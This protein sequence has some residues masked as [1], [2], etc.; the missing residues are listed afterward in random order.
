MS[1]RV[2]R[3]ALVALGSL[4]DLLPFYS[5]AK[6]LGLRG[7]SPTILASPLLER[8]LRG[9]TELPL[10]AVGSMSLPISIRAAPSSHVDCGQYRLLLGSLADELRVGEVARS[11]E[12]YLAEERPL[13]CVLHPFAVSARL[14]CHRLKVPVVE[15][16]M[17][18]CLHPGMASYPPV[19]YNVHGSD[20]EF[21]PWSEMIDHLGE[22]QGCF[23]MVDQ[24]Q[25]TDCTV[26]S[27]IGNGGWSAY[28]TAMQVAGAPVAIGL[29]T[30]DEGFLAGGATP[31]P[32]GACRYVLT[33]GSLCRRDAAAFVRLIGRFSFLPAASMAVVGC[34]LG[35]AAML[36]PMRHIGYAE[37]GWVPLSKCL[38]AESVLISHGGINTLNEGLRAGCAQ[39]VLPHGLDTGWNGRALADAGLGMLLDPT[40]SPEE[41]G[42]I[43]RTDALLPI[44]THA[45]ARRTSDVGALGKWSRIVE[46]MCDRAN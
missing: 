15:L 22:L 9:S 6:A 26:W 16:N 30:T 4:G 20:I 40:S 32:S 33:L 35:A 38:N 21:G 28:P 42:E 7:L 25:V 37:D 29:P 36:R 18:P 23:D 8:S 31:P 24:G 12:A 34:P 44:A 46:A 27:S 19:P 14:A 43:L 1:R 13:A 11:I 2:R 45:Y 39:I 41:L 3:V 5:L 17:Y 10:R